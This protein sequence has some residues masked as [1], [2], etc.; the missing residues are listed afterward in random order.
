MLFRSSLRDDR[1]M[2]QYFEA[3]AP[4]VLR[5]LDVSVLHRLVLE[6][7]LQLTPQSRSGEVGYVR[8]FD[9]AIAEAQRGERQFSVLLNPTCMKDVRDVANAGEKMPQKSSYFDPKL[10]SGLVFQKIVLDETIAS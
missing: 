7:L 5:L 6:D 10:L 3:K 2:D 1:V 9:E 4:K 8:S